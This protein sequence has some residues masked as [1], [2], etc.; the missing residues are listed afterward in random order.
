MRVT[1]YDV[2]AYLDAGWDA[3][4]I[5]KALPLTP[6]QIQEAIRYIEAHRAEMEAAHRRI[7]ERI[8]RGNPPHIEALLAESHVRLMALKAELAKRREEKNGEGN[9]GRR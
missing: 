2:Y 8:A 7:E 1:V 4:Q 9:P 6:E 3:E 5:R